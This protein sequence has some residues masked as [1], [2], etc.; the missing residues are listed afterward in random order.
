MKLVTGGTGL[1]GSH[2]LIELTK[3]NDSIRSIFR[4]EKKIEDVQNLFRYYY[5]KNW[6]HYWQKIEWIRADILDIESMKI[7]VSNVKEVYHSAGFVSFYNED[8]RKCIQIN[9]EGTANIVNLC[10]KYGI[11]KL[12]YVS[13]TAAIG[14]TEGKSITEQDKWQKTENTSGYSIS[15]YLAEKEVWRGIEE[16]LE[17][18]IINPCVILGPGNWNESSLK[19]FKN[20]SKGMTFYPTGSNATVDVRDVAS[21]LIKLVDSSICN[22]RFLCIGSNQSFESLLGEI[23]KHAGTKRPTKRISKSNLLLL[24]YLSLP[25]YWLFR[26][27]SPFNRDTIN[28][29]Y[30][31]LSYSRFEIEQTTNHSFYSLEETIKNTI[32]AKKFELEFK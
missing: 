29:A 21:C 25:F 31:N 26:I 19:I 32:N 16:G 14:G 12:G 24:Y 3:K 23:A 4:D 2:L 20:A 6:T 7:A 27:K 18:V 17:A 9:R 22:K 30:K 13:S 11:K 1:L 15:K 28:S 8:F 10:L 5:P